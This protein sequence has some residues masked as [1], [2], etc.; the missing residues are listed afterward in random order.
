MSADKAYFLPEKW[1]ILTLR[2]TRLSHWNT[3]PPAA[4]RAPAHIFPFLFLP[5]RV[6]LEQLPEPERAFFMSGK[7]RNVRVAIFG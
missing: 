4:H 2:A 7:K 3:A 1:D 5:A 6:L